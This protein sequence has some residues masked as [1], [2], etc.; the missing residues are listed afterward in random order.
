MRLRC[1]DTGILQLALVGSLLI[2]QVSLLLKLERMIKTDPAQFD[3]T[4]EH[5]H[6]KDEC[7]AAQQD[8]NAA[9]LLLAEHKKCAAQNFKLSRRNYRAPGSP[10]C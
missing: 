4:N 5:T 9:R 3:W 10:Y 2:F 7:K 8:L 6:W 1:A